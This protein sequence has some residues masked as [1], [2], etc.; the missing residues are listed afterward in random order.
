MPS[1]LYSEEDLDLMKIT[2]DSLN[3]S[4][5]QELIDFA[6]LSNYKK[7]GIANCMSMQKYADKLKTILEEN[8]F[9][10]F[11]I[12]CKNSGLTYSNL[13]DDDTK[14]LSCDPAS[15]AQYL[16]ESKTDFNINVGLCLGHGLVFSKYSTAPNT[17]L[18][19][20]DFATKHKTIEELE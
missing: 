1:S 13:F 11:A 15:Q 8:D 16:N 19:V 4:R 6:K 12:N 10:V 3:K 17:T 14:G 7:I 20:K 5:I 2:K 18:V 9:E